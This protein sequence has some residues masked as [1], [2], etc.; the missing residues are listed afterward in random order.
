MLTVVPSSENKKRTGKKKTGARSDLFLAGKGR[1][2]YPV[3]KTLQKAERFTRLELIRA[4]RQLSEADRRMKRSGLSG[5][6]ILEHVIL[7][8]CQANHFTNISAKRADHRQS[9]RRR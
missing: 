5:Q 3:Y 1:S 4:L 7:A 2:P 8:I 6:L 9:D